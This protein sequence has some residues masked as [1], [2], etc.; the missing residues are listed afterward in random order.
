[1]PDRAFRS[2]RRKLVAWDH[3]PPDPFPGFLLGFNPC[4]PTSRGEVRLRDPDPWSAPVIE[5]R[6]LSTRYDR[7]QMMAGAFIADAR[8]MIRF[9]S[10]VTRSFR[11]G[12]CLHASKHRSTNDLSA[13]GQSFLPPPPLADLPPPAPTPATLPAEE[14]AGGAPAA[15]A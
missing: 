3:N 2:R 4:R 9:S 11:P 12:S 8:S 10:F 14:D 5:P 7:D 13:G 15:C 6:Y 1:M